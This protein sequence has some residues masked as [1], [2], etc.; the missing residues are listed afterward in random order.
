MVFVLFLFFI[1]KK[2][3][4][5]FIHCIFLFSFF[6]Y[7][8]ASLQQKLSF[9]TLALCFGFSV[10]RLRSVHLGYA[11][12]PSPS[13][14]SA[15]EAKEAFCYLTF[16]SRASVLRLCKRSRSEGFAEDAQAHRLRRRRAST[17]FFGR[18]SSL[19]ERSRSTEEAKE[20]EAR[21]RMHGR[22]TK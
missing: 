13:V 9:F 1:L 5:V 21:Q 4:F 12:A 18:A 7:F 6:Y 17:R 10:T 11:F 19:R 16:L 8:F 14:M 15:T 3:S 20:E 22:R 2:I